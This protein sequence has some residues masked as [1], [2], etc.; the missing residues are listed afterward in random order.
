LIPD[1]AVGCKRRIIDYSYF[2][3]LHFKNLTLTMEAAKDIVPEGVRMDKSNI[4]A[5]VIIMANGF[6][7]NKFVNLMRVFGRQGKSLAEHWNSFGGA[8]DTFVLLCTVPCVC[9]IFVPL[10]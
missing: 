9:L 10:I 8:E 1:F 3:S 5:D 2:R 7:I 4:K 6:R